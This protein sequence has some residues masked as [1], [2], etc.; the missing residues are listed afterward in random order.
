M[1]KHIF[2]LAVSLM[3][4]GFSPA[5]AITISIEAS[6][7]RVGCDFK[8]FVSP[9]NSSSSSQLDTD[10]Q[11][12]INACGAD[13][14][15]QAWNLDRRSGTSMCF[16]KNC[17][18]QKS[19]SVGVFGGVKFPFTMSNV[20]ISVDRPGCDYVIFAVTDR[21]ARVCASNNGLCGCSNACGF[22][23]TCQAWN[24]YFRTATPKC[25]L[26]SCAPLPTSSVGNLSGVKF[27]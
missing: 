21:D 25:F 7:D 19:I 17:V 16:L 18:P 20:E 10:V 13:S 1:E 24:V 22:D 14:N 27:H 5:H 15:C 9:R 12:C 3:I 23:S 8:N 11:V 4:F 6:I 2:C 26:K